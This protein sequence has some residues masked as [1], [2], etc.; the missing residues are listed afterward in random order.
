[1]RLTTRGRP[2]SRI[3]LPV[4]LRAR[5]RAGPSFANSVD[6]S[7]PV[8]QKQHYN[9]PSRCDAKPPSVPASAPR[10][11][12]TRYS[13]GR[14]NRTFPANRQVPVEK[15]QHGHLPA[16]NLWC[17]FREMDVRYPPRDIVARGKTWIRFPPNQGFNLAVHPRPFSPP[18]FPPYG[19][20]PAKKELTMFRPFAVAALWLVLFTAAAV[21]Q[22]AD[23]QPS[24]ASVV[25]STSALT[26]APTATDPGLATAASHDCGCQGQAISEPC[27]TCG[28]QPRM[29]QHGYYRAMRQSMADDQCCGDCLGGF[30]P[31]W[32]TYC[33]DKQRCGGSTA[34]ESGRVCA[35]APLCAPA[36]RLRLP[37]LP[38]RG[39]QRHCGCDRC[40]GTTA[41][42]DCDTMESPSSTEHPVNIGSP[43]E[44]TEAQPSAPPPVPSDTEAPATEP[45]NKVTSARRGW[46]NRTIGWRSSR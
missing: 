20:P 29:R 45:E 25:P 36:V 17:M 23:L 2:A 33:T 43:P 24:D 8:S 11:V 6:N 4:P 16:A 26:P 1:M 37:S 31:L 22:P 27:T 5:A 34:C 7:V 10:A 42:C 35:P 18:H 21:A 3:R 14:Y 30:G 46:M 40:G 38:R 13:S 39:L 41:S 9:Q 12:V 28:P 32:A 44:P 19:T 15:N